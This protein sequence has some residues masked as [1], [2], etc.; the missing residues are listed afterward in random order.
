M[1][2]AAALALW[3]SL[4]SCGLGSPIAATTPVA[5]TTTTPD[6]AASAPRITP[7]AVTPPTPPGTTLPAFKCADVS[8]G[9]AG[10]ANVTAVRMSELA[11]YDRFVIQFDAKV[12]TYTVK[13]QAKPSFKSGGSGQSITLSGAAGALVQVHSATGAGSYTGSTDMSHGEFLVL[14]EARLVE[15]FEGYLGWG[16]G[17]SKPACL[18]AFTLAGPPRL[19]VDFSTASR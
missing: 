19:V 2:T 11:G 10:S 15:D 1:R 4:T 3:V 13:R 8:G 9:A 12:P 7:P 14:N 17:L 5:G 6:Q 18:R 16:L